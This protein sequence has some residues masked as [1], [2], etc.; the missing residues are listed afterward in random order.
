VLALMLHTLNA[1]GIEMIFNSRRGGCA[2][3]AVDIFSH[4]GADDHRDAFSGDEEKAGNR[5]PCICVSRMIG[6]IAID[7]ADR[8][9][10]VMGRAA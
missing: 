10:A 8:S 1:A 2:R 5:K 9:E 4:A 6:T 3:C 7:T